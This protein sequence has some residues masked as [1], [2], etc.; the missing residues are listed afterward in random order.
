MHHNNS[1]ELARDIHQA[2]F[3]ILGKL[4]EWMRLQCICF[5]KEPDVTLEGSRQSLPATVHYMSI[6]SQI[7]NV[8]ETRGW[9]KLPTQSGIQR[10]MNCTLFGNMRSTQNY[11][12]GNR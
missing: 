7:H 4:I 11:P 3:L 9:T 6:A 12:I 1:L 8:L 10:N 5:R 2:S